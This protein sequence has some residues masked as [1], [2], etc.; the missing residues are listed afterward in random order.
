[1]A[2]STPPASDCRRCAAN[3]A[4]AR[5]NAGNLSYFSFESFAAAA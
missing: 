5:L 3:G 4:T 1:M 2:A